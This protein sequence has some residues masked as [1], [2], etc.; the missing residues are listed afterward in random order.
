MAGISDKA[1]KTQYAENKYRGNGGVELQNKEFSDG[2]G[3]EAYDAN[4]RMYDPQIGRFWQQDPLGDA[5]EGWGSYSFVNDNPVS[6]NDPLGLVDSIPGLKPY[7]PAPIVRPMHVHTPDNT[8]PGLALIGTPPGAIDIPSAPTTPPE[9][10]INIPN[11]EG[12]PGGEPTVGPLVPGLTVLSGALT[13]V[14][15]LMWEGGP[16]FPDNDE[17]YVINHR[18]APLPGGDLVPYEGHGNNKDNSNPHIV[19]AFGFAA[20]DG[21]TP[22]LKYGISDEYRNF[23]N[24]PESQLAALRA[25]YGPTVMYSIYT[26]TTNRVEA[27]IIEAGLVAEHKLMWNG[28]L[29]REQLRPNP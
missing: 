20:K 5:N 1:V 15:V 26:R 22:I 10:T 6:F 4:F 28:A 11:P 24:R 12:G 16:D 25:K 7:A 29:P 3:L 13:V 21:K 9:I 23:M 27:L 2:S 19:Y 18:G 8:L 14:G 17:G